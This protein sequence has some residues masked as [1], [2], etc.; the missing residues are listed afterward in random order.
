M[1]HTHYSS[2]VVNESAMWF[3][4]QVFPDHSDTVE[5]VLKDHLIC[6]KSAV[7][8]D[9]WS[10]ATGSCTLKCVTFCQKLV[11]I[12]DRWFLMAV[13]S[14]DRFHCSSWSYLVHL[15]ILLS[16]LVVFSH[17]E[18]ELFCNKHAGQLHVKLIPL[19]FYN[20]GGIT[21]HCCL[22]DQPGNTW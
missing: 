1:R 11:V 12:Q 18:L 10:L 8:Q 16:L 21:S 19:L 5:P 22:T 6:L 2:T 7:S 14:Q 9:R 3:W 17:C 15:P 13:V 20:Q 4:R